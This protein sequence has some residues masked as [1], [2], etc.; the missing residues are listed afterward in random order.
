MII[1]SSSPS[2]LKIGRRKKK[3][4]EKN[5]FIKRWT[6]HTYLH[7]YIKY[8]LH[9]HFSA[10]YNLIL[11]K[12]KKKRKPYA[13]AL[14]T[15]AGIFMHANTRIFHMALSLYKKTKRRGGRW[16][17]IL[18]KSELPCVNKRYMYVGTSCHCFTNF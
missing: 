3:K 1:H 8:I 17:I 18:K 7:T 9:I 4:R 16:K 10:R 11:E 6:D 12:K 13:L 2:S 14:F 15:H 5:F